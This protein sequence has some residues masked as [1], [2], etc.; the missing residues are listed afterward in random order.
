MKRTWLLLLLPAALLLWW[1]LS[2]RDIAPE[3]HFSTAV[4]STI[5][6][7]ISTNGKV[8]PAEWAA[9]RTA[10]AGIVSRVSVQKGQKVTQGQP[11]IS[12]DMR[13]AQTDLEGALA[14]KEEAQAAASAIN[15]GGKAA[16]VASLNDSLQTA[17]AAVTVA[18]R[19][20]DS[21]Q[22]L[23][24]QQAATK[25]QVDEAKDALDRAKLQAES[26]ENQR[27]TLVTPADKSEALARVNDAQAAVD[28]AE[29]RLQYGVV[30]APLSGTLYQFDI[31]E[32]A[33]LPPG[34]LVGLVGRLDRVKVIVYVDEPDLGRVSL[35]MPVSIT[36]DALPG[37]KWT[38]RVDHLPSEVI[39]L[40]TRTVGEVTTIVDNPDHDLLPGVTVNV[41]II[42]S[43][44]KDATSVPKAALRSMHGENGVYK[45]SGDHIE[46]APVKVG[47]SDINNVE[48][49]SGVGAGDKVADRVVDPSDAE[50]KAGMR[51]KPQ[52]N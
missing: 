3:I 15:Q 4:K 11:L 29:A 50:L 14:R 2:R 20:Y 33:Y 44:V 31:K 8:E 41:I 6:S 49:L 26:I 40:G 16:T 7:T 27:R 13:L 9:A 34:E 32:G 48:V 12:L 10:T 19:N 21:L 39:A 24:P 47:A 46:W 5:E 37:K 52:F 30:R 42:S 1:G 45:L 28:L 38:G 36:W 23:L 18:Q 17:K 35:G 25:L 22:R 43:V 51:V